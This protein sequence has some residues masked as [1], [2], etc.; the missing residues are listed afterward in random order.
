MTKF[1]LQITLN[2]VQRPEKATGLLIPVPPVTPDQQPG[3]LLV[4]PSWAARRFVGDGGIQEALLAVPT[5]EALQSV[6][7]VTVELRQGP[8]SISH[9]APRA[10]STEPTD[11]AQEI[12]RKLSIAD[13]ARDEVKL[14]K[15]IEWV[16]SNYDYKHGH[17]P[18]L[19]LTCDMLTGNCLD[20]NG[21]L[22]K[23][24]RIASIKNAYYIGYY[25]P[26]AEM[27]GAWHCWVS[28]LSSRGYECWDIAH[29]LK[30]G[31]STVAPGLNPVGGM[32]FAMSTGR[33]LK[34]DLPSGQIVVSHLARPRWVLSD[35]RTA[36]CT[37]TVVA[38]TCDSEVL[39]APVAPLQE[40]L[41]KYL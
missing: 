15:L 38:Q 1:R 32:R 8:P 22:M 35:G 5:E 24:L 31:I 40:S 16:A 14:L 39:T 13:T 33:D 34:F 41:L 27:H 30:R 2:D 26:P 20:I 23:L 10:G 6:I 12:Y 7:E 3:E 28:T 36:E 37:V 4:H 19:A 11:D 29:H 17:M 21:A 18:G 25:F 9:F